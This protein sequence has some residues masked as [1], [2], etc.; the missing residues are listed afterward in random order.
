MKTIENFKLIEFFNQ[1]KTL[2][3]EYLVALGYI[4][5]IETEQELFHMKFKH[6]ELVKSAFKSQDNVELIEAVSKV[7]KV[8]KEAV[9]DMRII[10][11]FG[12]VNSIKKQLEAL[13]HAESVRLV[14]DIINPKWE[15]VNGSEKMSKFGIYNTLEA[16]SGGDILKYKEIMN[17][18]Y[19]EVF[20]V[21][22]MRKT[23]AELKEQ[24]NKIK[25]V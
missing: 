15:A 21:L 16:L 20:T 6:V 5:P 24:M 23:S 7:Q 1:D 3:E 8:E 22:Y 18:E 11:F 25:T 19:S 2:I 13:L 12:I 14:P 10:K 9:L 17:L 4:K